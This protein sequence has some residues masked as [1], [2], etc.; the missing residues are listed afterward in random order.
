MKNSAIIFIFLLFN[1]VA[2]K[3]STFLKKRRHVPLQNRAASVDAAVNLRG[4]ALDFRYFVAGGTC[5]AISHGITTPIDVVKTRMQSEP[6]VY[7]KGLI[8]ATV[9]IVQNNGFGSL[10]A[11]LGP[12][13]IGYAIEGAMKFGVYE[14]TKPIMIKFL[15]VHFENVNIASA[16]LLSSVIAG[17]VAAILLCPMESARIRVV[18]DPSFEG[19]N[20][21]STLGRLVKEDGFLQLFGGLW[22]MLAKQ[23]PY[24]MGKQVS[25]DMFAG[26][27][28]SIVLTSFTSLSKEDI[29]WVVSFGAAF[30][31]SIF[32]CI[33][34]QPGDMILTATYKGASD[35]RG[36]VDIIAEIYKSSGFA[37][38]FTGTGARLVHVCSIITSQ[39]M[40][41]DVV[42]QA[43][44]LPATGSH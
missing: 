9:D 16:F 28:Y 34:S 18:T 41:Y 19:M 1:S 44:G 8:S 38:F 40:I 30:I 36:F 26:L 43:L 17:A 29:K 23:V 20:T 31:A 12:T 4:G 7:N 39:L 42:K 13:V 27:L 14:V 33:T 3:S 5:A 2:S 35:G 10:L 22:A 11:G 6:E 15:G 25:F 21:V 24:T 37:G 32:A